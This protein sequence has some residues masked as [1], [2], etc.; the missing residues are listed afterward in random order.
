M[1]SQ[2]IPPKPCT[3][4]VSKLSFCQ[5]KRK[6]SRLKIPE[7]EKRKFIYIFLSI[8]VFIDFKVSLHSIFHC[9]FLSQDKATT[10]VEKR[11]IIFHRRVASVSMRRGGEKKLVSE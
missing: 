6:V 5:L 2:S 4:V 9:N 1:I 8:I 11:K 3:H 10:V 7:R